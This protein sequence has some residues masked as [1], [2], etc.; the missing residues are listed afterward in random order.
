MS[1]RSATASLLAGVRLRTIWWTKR[2]RLMSGKHLLSLRDLQSFAAS[3]RHGERGRFVVQ[4]EGRLKDINYVRNVVG[5]YR[6]RLDGLIARRSDLRR[7]SQGE[8][9]IFARPRKS[10]RAARRY[11]IN[12]ASRGGRSIRPNRSASRSEGDHVARYFVEGAG[13]GMLAAGDGVCA[14]PDG[15]LVGTVSAVWKATGF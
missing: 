2:K 10:F 8:R 4:I 11:Y 12:G 14:G 1:P 13:L 9:W 15:G 5:W 7:A 3:G 6:N